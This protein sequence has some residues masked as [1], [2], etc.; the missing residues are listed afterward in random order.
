MH[1]ELIYDINTWWCYIYVMKRLVSQIIFILVIFL[2]IQSSKSNTLQH[3]F[4]EAKF[5]K[6]DIWHSL[7]TCCEHS[8]TYSNVR[9]YKGRQ[10]AKFE[11]RRYDRDVHKS[12]RSE[13]ATGVEKA[14]GDNWYRFKMFIPNDWKTDP[15]S[16][17]IIAQWHGYPDLD[18][19]ETW[20]SPPLSMGIQGNQITIQKQ[21][22][23]KEVTINNNPEGKSVLWEGKLDGLK[24]KWVDWTFHIKWSYLQDGIVE[25]WKDK[26]QIISRTGANSY[27]DEKGVYLK[28]GIY[29]PDWKH[30][31]EKSVVDYRIIYFDDVEIGYGQR[32]PGY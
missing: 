2:G 28:I 27:N 16:F 23:S 5:K 20:R 31:A 4:E 19:G 1:F 22:D 30:N 12:K 32:I 11:L 26:E 17:E 24:G 14:S 3:D 21:W 13:L 29:K 10:S 9:S 8:Y 15:N 7:E 18:K 25:V 6:G